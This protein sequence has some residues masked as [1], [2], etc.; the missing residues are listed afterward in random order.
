MEGRVLWGD[1][2]N[3]HTL[4]P[5]YRHEGALT[6]INPHMHHTHRATSPHRLR[7]P[8][9]TFAGI[10][11]KRLQ[12]PLWELSVPQGAPLSFWAKNMGTGTREEK[13]YRGN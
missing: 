11:P 2:A 8:Y 12:K 3:R 6:P 13:A 7:H 4:Y 1:G 9:P 5:T 10:S